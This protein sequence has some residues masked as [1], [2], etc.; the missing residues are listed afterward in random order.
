MKR[1]WWTLPLV[2][3]LVIAAGALLFLRGGSSQGGLPPVQLETLQGRPFPLQNLTQSGKPIVLNTW[4]TWCPPC[5]RELPLLVQTAQSYPQVQFVFVD[6][7]QGPEAV[8]LFESSHGLQLPFVLLDPNGVLVNQLAISG[9]P[10]TFFFNA[11]G[12]LV[13]RHDGEIN[14][15]ILLRDLQKIL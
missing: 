13:A 4:A 7:Q 3:I 9:I 8:K 12:Q 6:L 15:E 10:D 2:G 1:R 14:P 5:Q 11:H